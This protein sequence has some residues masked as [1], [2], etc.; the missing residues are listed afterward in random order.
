MGDA[1]LPV[2]G[3]DF[4][5]EQT[6]TQFAIPAG[7]GATF[8]AA[9]SIATITF[10]AAHGLTLQPAANVPPNYFITFGGTISGVTGTGTLIGNIFRILSIPSATAITI[11]TTITA[12]NITAVTGIPVFYP[13]LQSSQQSAFVGGP[14]QT[15]AGTVT[16]FA[17]AYVQGATVNY[18][19]GANCAVR[20]NPDLKA[21]ILDGASTPA[22]GATPGTAPVWRDLVSVNN[23]SQDWLF[24]PTCAI[25]A[26]GGSGTSFFSQLQ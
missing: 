26:N 14:T 21:V 13:W 10:N 3:F 1:R 24:A 9:N 11:Y 7:G 20:Y 4:F 22:L 15:I 19:L 6:I 17:P 5:A 12:A 25:W 2:A 8:S 18:S 16:P 23:P